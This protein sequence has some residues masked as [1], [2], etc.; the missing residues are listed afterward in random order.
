MLK[1]IAVQHIRVQDENAH[2]N[3][4]GDDVLMG[5]AA[6]SLVK[7][8][9]VL[10]PDGGALNAHFNVTDD[11]ILAFLFRER[12][13]NVTLYV[14]TLPISKNFSK[15]ML[16]V[17]LNVFSGDNYTEMSNAKVKRLERSAVH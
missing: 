14:D 2:A 4:L 13:E 17:C 12:H 7:L 1:L 16:Q 9:M 8:H 3:H 5:M 10:G 6:K 11:G 15:L